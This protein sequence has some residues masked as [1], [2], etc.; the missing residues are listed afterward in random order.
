MTDFTELKSK[1][2]DWLSRDDLASQIPTF[3]QFAENRINRKLRL[4]TMET[5]VTLNTVKAQRYYALPDR[6]AA[7]R[8]F[9]LNLSPI[10]T[11]NYLTPQ[12]F[13]MKWAGSNTGVPVVYSIIGDELELGPAPD[14]I[15]EMEMTVYRKFIPLSDAN[16]SNWLTTNAFDVILY[17][18]CLEASLFVQDKKA[19]DKW[20][21]AYKAAVDDIILDDNLDRHSGG[22]LMIVPDSP[23]F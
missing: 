6:Y 2:A 21:A 8:N 4:R 16:P 7:M 1:T 12:N 18:S 22:A 23:R 13:D 20:A 9:K 10:R 5:R 17:A 15:Y 14:G 19:Q 3:I 11:L